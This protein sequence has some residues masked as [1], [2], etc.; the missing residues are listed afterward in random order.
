M[1][2]QPL[3]GWTDIAV[4]ASCPPPYIP[5]EPGA[6]LQQDANTR[7][8]EGPEQEVPSRAGGLMYAI[9]RAATR[10]WRGMGV[11][12]GFSIRT[13]NIKSPVIS[14]QISLP[15]AHKVI[16]SIELWGTCKVGSW[17]YFLHCQT[18]A[19][20]RCGNA[21]CENGGS[22]DSEAATATAEVHTSVLL[23]ET[24]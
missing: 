23:P 20:L 24:D 18:S 15:G 7:A 21:E 22:T 16:L 13:L 9:S 17:S 6:P 11:H 12:R 2:T 3:T 19:N 1:N 5:A 10:L 4:L 8:L 14:L